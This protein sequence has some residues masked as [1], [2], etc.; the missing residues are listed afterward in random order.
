MLP[1]SL[2]RKA[3]QWGQRAAAFLGFSIPISVALDNVLLLLVVVLWLMGGGLKRKFAFVAAHPVALAAL[4]LF[5]LLLAGLAWGERYPGDGLRYL[6][7]Y[8]ELLFIPVFV[9]LFREARMREAALRWFCA[10]M[11]LSFIVA[12]LIAL[13]LLD[14]NALLN[15]PPEYTGAFKPSITHGLFSAFAA[16]LFALL[17]LREP[18]WPRRL[19]FA[20]LALIAVK[21]VALVSISR[22]AYLV[23]AFLVIY[24]FF[25]L[26]RWRG[27]AAAGVLLLLLFAAL[28]HGSAIFRERVD[29]VVSSKTDLQ[30]QWP[31]RE[32]VT[33][34]M[35]WYQ[36]SLEI[37]RE[38]PLLGAGTGSYPRA[39]AGAAESAP[40]IRTPNPHNEY[41]LI[42][43]QTGLA[44]L[45][46]LLCLFI[47]Q[48]RLAPR[49]ATPLETHL[50]RGLVIT[51]A[52]GCLFNSFLLDHTEGL[53]YAWL[54]GVLYGGLQARP[55]PPT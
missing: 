11:V 54:T 8:E 41:L 49:L 53:F 30:Y 44:G 3:E 2:S 18:G 22:T 34:R 20:A 17:A 16:F 38:H 24:G 4:A 42:A 21:N 28:Y 51:L 31:S 48:Y 39:F 55:A 37:L 45:A 10:A 5:G 27:L 33:D 29:T 19:L 46:L 7:K 13:G 15:R 47:S 26:Y 35:K 43:A 12:E 36:R 40:G 1:S 23:L 14:G 32:S 6:G 50:A 9:T 25:A 52:V